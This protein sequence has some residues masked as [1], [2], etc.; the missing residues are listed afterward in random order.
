VRP[1]CGEVPAPLFNDD[2]GLVE[3]VE[4]LAVQLF[5]A[6]ASIEAFVEHNSELVSHSR[7]SEQSPNR[8]GW[9]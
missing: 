3:R 5:V 9:R 2:L 4:Y 1:D 6:E 7:M 8:S